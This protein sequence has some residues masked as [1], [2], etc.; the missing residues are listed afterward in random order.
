MFN[1]KANCFEY[2]QPELI[3]HRELNKI[4]CFKVIYEYGKITGEM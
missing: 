2:Y 1:G 3:D 4:I